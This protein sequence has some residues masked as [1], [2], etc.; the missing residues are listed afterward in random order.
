MAELRRSHKERR[1]GLRDVNPGV[2]TVDRA[3]VCEHQLLQDGSPGGS[4]SQ[5]GAPSRQITS[6]EMS[7][8]GGRG[9][10][11]A[12]GCQNQQIKDGSPGGSPSQ[13]CLPVQN[14]SPSQK[15]SPTQTITSPEMSNPGGGGAN[16]AG[17]CE[18]QEIQAGSPGGSPSQ[19]S[20]P[21]QKGSPSQ[22]G[23]PSRQ[24]TGHEMSIPGGGGADRAGVCEYQEIQDGSPGGSPSQKS[25]PMQSIS[26]IQTISTANNQKVREAGSPGGSPSQKSSPVQKGSPIQLKSPMRT[27]QGKHR[28]SASRKVVSSQ[29]ASPIPKPPPL[30][31]SI[32]NRRR[33]EEYT[34]GEIFERTLGS[35]TLNFA[36]IPHA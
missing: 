16:R 11:R 8:P 36:M 29:S 28:N 20:S 32:T 15:S 24:I 14:G 12:G 1:Q 31:A 23:A 26:P 33:L 19:K 27:G 18:N 21:V 9:V 30:L 22:T 34:R 2:R 3:G 5:T 35:A 4:P 17:G 25:S 6:H 13:N 7:I 10:D